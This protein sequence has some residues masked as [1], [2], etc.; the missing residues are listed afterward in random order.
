MKYTGD[1]PRYAELREIGQEMQPSKIVIES[2]RE[3][4]DHRWAS[5]TRRDIVIRVVCWGLGAMGSGIARNA[6][7]KDQIH[8]VGAIDRDER[9]KGKDLGEYLG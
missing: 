6:A 8:V 7:K 5:K 4:V 9:L 2:L 1:K 3:A